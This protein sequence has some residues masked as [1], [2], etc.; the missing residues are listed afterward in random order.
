MITRKTKGT[1]ISSVQTRETRTELDSHADTCVVGS[2]A[3][4]FQ[5]FGRPVQ[6]SAYDPSLGTKPDMKV[7]S[8]ALAYDD[9]NNG[10][11]KIL[12]VHQ[13]IL[14]PTM[15]H[16][17]LSPMQMRLNGVTVQECPRFL[18]THLNEHSHSIK[19][20]GP[21][22]DVL[23]IPLRIHGV[24]SYFPTR[25]PS[26][27]EFETGDRFELTTETPE[28]DPHDPTYAQQEDSFLNGDWIL[29]S[30]DRSGQSSFISAL[31][32]QESNIQ[33]CIIGELSS[34]S[35]QVLM[36]IDPNLD[37]YCFASRLLQHYNVSMA[38]S[39]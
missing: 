21:D 34:N 32:L 19:V 11:V 15:D 12:I 1:V 36:E 28:W 24:T 8:A 23:N 3:L 35:S 20:P 4:V 14:V 6:V 22:G 9:P 16:N 39:T 7:V 29:A 17:L 10:E 5:D 33:P 13:A 30:G 18:D 2:E 27:E 25:K 26:Q 37:A 38:S 31:A